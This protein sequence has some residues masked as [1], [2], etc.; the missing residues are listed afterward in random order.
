MS[1]SS[2]YDNINFNDYSTFT[3]FNVS[4]GYLT[5]YEWS[6]GNLEYSR[7]DGLNLYS[8][9]TFNIHDVT[10]YNCH[11]SS[12]I[13]QN[14]QNMI[15]INTLSI[16]SSA[17]LSIF[18]SSC[19][20]LYVSSDEMSYSESSLY[21]EN[22][23]VNGSSRF[24]E[25][26]SVVLN[27]C[28]LQ[29]ST[30]IYRVNWQTAAPK[31]TFQSTDATITKEPSGST[32]YNNT[33]D[34]LKIVGSS[35]TLIF[36]HVKILELSSYSSVTL[37]VSSY[38]VYND[39]DGT[40]NI[41]EG[42]TQ[43][44]NGNYFIGGADII[45]LESQVY[46]NIYIFDQAQVTLTN[47]TVTGDIEIY[48]EATLLMQ[49]EG[50]FN[51]LFLNEF[52]TV[53]LN[54]ISHG[55]SITGNDNSTLIISHV[56][57]IG[58]ND[59]NF[60]DGASVQV[61]DSSFYDNINFND[62]S[63]F[64]FFNVSFGYLTLYEWSSGNLEYSRGDGL[65]LYSRRTFNIHDVTVYNCH[66]SSPIPQNLQ[67]M[68]IIN[69]LSIYSS[70]TLSIFNSSC[71]DLYVSSDE[72]SYSESSLYAENLL[73]NGSS[74]FIENVSVVLNSCNLQG[75]T[76][77]YRVNWQTAA[78]KVTFQSTDATITKE[79][80][81]STEYN[82]TADEII[83]YQS[84]VTFIF[85]FVKILK[86]F[87]N[88]II[89]NQN[90]Q[91]GEIQLDATS[92]LVGDDMDFDGLSDDVE[93][94]VYLT[95]PN[96]P[97]SDGDGYG[98]GEEV[99]WGGDP[100]DP[101]NFPAD[102]E[103]PSLVVLGI[104]NNSIYHE[105]LQINISTEDNRGI[106]YVTVFLNDSQ[107]Y[108]EEVDSDNFWLNGNIS[109]LVDLNTEDYVDGQ[110]T[111]SIQS[112]DIHHRMTEIRFNIGIDNTPVY[113]I[114][115]GP[116]NIENNSRISS[117]ILLEFEFSEPPQ[118]VFYAWDG[119]LN[120]TILQYVPIGDGLHY[121]DIYTCDSIGNWYHTRYTFIVDDSVVLI[122][123]M[124]P[125]NNSYINS[126]T[127]IVIEF[128]DTPSDLF[129]SW[130]GS[131]NST[132]LPPLPSTQGL[133]ILDIWTN[134]SMG[135][136]NHEQFSF[137]VDDFAPNIILVDP[138][139]N[140]THESGYFINITF[141]EP[142]QY[143]SYAWDGRENFTTNPYLPIGDGIHYL[144]VY[145]ED[146]VPN[147]NHTRYYFVTDD[148]LILILNSPT[149]G[150]ILRSNMQINMTILGTD[151]TYV[152]NWDGG[153]N[154]T[155]SLSEMPITP[156]LD[157]VHTLNVFLVDNLGNKLQQSFT[158]FISNP[159][160]EI[161]L[162]SPENNSI[163]KDETN[164]VIVF[165]EDPVIVLYSWNGEE[166]TTTLLPIPGIEGVYILTVYA[167]NI[168]GSWSSAQFRWE[169]NL[170]DPPVVE[171][172]YPVGGE[173]ISGEFTISWHGTDVDNDPL[174]YDLYYSPDN[175]QNWISIVQGLS[176][177][178][179]KWNTTNI[180]EG[181][182]LV[183]V[184]AFDGYDQ[185]EAILSKAIHIKSD[186]NPFELPDFIPGYTTYWLLSFGL[187]VVAL[188]VNRR[189]KE[190]K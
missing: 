3:F 164:V 151:G 48:G 18:N 180:P 77:I 125:E 62:Y 7:G 10:V 118:L 40:G 120:T 177:E 2:F 69:T 100:T 20:D 181:E 147:R 121:L 56:H 182:Y 71:K 134:S 19:K 83:L 9:R 135:N 85:I 146:F 186:Y 17:T 148:P 145:V 70:A 53:T 29:G 112:Y 58:W 138:E 171:L 21:A 161:N 36:M 41:Q 154:Q 115:V 104:T 46:S 162:V 47:V 54:A 168:H 187:L 33:A 55:D 108:F 127:E 139:N 96:N 136:W 27:S 44:I 157:G 31:V 124:S 68:I 4:F 39:V 66:V 45:S 141:S 170:N 102:L 111:L 172:I 99:R 1:D 64:T 25:N 101:L 78:P 28:N 90:A 38:D 132:T 11:V 123:L 91:F 114:L 73:V 188:K 6:S 167:Q 152:Y 129:F 86:A 107:I 149:E 110:Y 175:G 67:N 184:I 156:I 119:G 95:D 34:E 13:P 92:K 51:R 15:I 23:L 113:P 105:N 140:S 30:Y 87:E 169:V 84:D 143:I 59:H 14:L 133:H 5:L 76:Y 153:E 88:S 94:Q 117:G 166:N 190:L 60:Y 150:S 42:G 142:V 57:S 109:N 63:T 144:D 79:P 61:S 165:S 178:V 93:T 24:I 26:V 52:S 122:Y 16:Y 176:V 35:V 72:M 130:D 75:S 155:V 160:I 137:I 126:G 173:E 97:D 65:N 50:S 163:L 116:Y 49:N 82:N 98:D 183:K 37:I 103:N 185:G 128:S 189:S 43:L 8:R 158:F 22:L 131:P 74:R 179:Y 80:S 89:H 81:G 174:T 32:E 106:D 159:L 12:P